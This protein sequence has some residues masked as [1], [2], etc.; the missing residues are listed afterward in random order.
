[1]PF[2]AVRAAGMFFFSNPLKYA[3]FYVFM[4]EMNEKNRLSVNCSVP[5]K[6]LHYRKLREMAIFA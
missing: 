6:K 1:M 2:G 3:V 4:A 5:T